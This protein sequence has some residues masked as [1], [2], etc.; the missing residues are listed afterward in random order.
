[1]SGPATG[2][3]RMRRA[4]LAASC[5]VLTVVLSACESTEQESAR[6]GREGQRLVA[7]QSG[8]ALGAVNHSVRVADVTLLT[9]GGRAAVAGRAVLNA[10]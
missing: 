3:P 9:S 7:S 5:G 10:K 2:T 6:I 4:L 8:L 1:M